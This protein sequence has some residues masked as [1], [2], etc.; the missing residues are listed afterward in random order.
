MEDLI[1]SIVNVFIGVEKSLVLD[2]TNQ[3]AFQDKSVAFFAMLRRIE[4]ANSQKGHVA[5]RE[6]WTR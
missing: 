5:V 6:I 4:V 3:Q 2:A 1:I